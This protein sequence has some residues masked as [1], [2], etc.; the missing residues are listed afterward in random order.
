MSRTGCPAHRSPRR[1]GRRAVW[2]YRA[3]VR[4]DCRQRLRRRDHRQTQCR[5]SCRR[6]RQQPSGVGAPHRP[7]QGRIPAQ[8]RRGRNKPSTIGLRCAAVEYGDPENRNARRARLLNPAVCSLQR[9][10]QCDDS[11]GDS[12]DATRVGCCVVNLRDGR[13]ARGSRALA[14]ASSRWRGTASRSS[15]AGS[16]RVSK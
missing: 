5:A 4:H 15:S 11:R 10:M 7:G 6:R 1:C 12:R 3:A 14:R 16:A 9:S 13:S 2:A 8:A